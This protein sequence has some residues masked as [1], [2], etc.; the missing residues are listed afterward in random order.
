[1]AAKKDNLKKENLMTRRTA[2]KVGLA[3]VAGLTLGM[4]KLFGVNDVLGLEQKKMKVI[5]INGSARKD[6]N[7]ATLLQQALD[8][9][10][11]QGAETEMVHLFDIKYKGCVSCLACKLKNARTNGLCAYKD[12]LTPLLQKCREADALIFG[13]PIYYDNVDGMMRSFLERLMFPL[14]PYTVNHEGQRERFLT[15]TVPVGF[16]Y[17][18]NCPEQMRENFYGPMF[19]S[20]EGY[21]SHI[22]GSCHAVYSTNTYQYKDYSRYDVNLFR[23]EDKRKWRDEQFPKDKQKSYELG[24]LLVDEVKK[25]V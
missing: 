7:T 25:S 17:T 8:G 23:E 2:I 6:M 21:L 15:G 18:M 9:A 12:A 20:V 22:F 16:I 19:K 5:A 24:K 1:M 14:D 11:A 13:S 4:Q 10:A 3:G